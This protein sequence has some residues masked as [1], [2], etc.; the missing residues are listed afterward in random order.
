MSEQ[1]DMVIL[2]AGINGVAIAKT[3]ARL[4]KRKF[5]MSTVGS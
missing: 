2:G 4:G 3:L 5:S 1:Y